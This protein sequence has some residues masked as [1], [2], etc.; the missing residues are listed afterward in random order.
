M[1]EEKSPDI[2]EKLLPGRGDNKIPLAFWG[3]MWYNEDN[4]SETEGI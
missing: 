2:L 4:L 1:T 3:C